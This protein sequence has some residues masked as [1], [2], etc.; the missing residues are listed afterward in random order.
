MGVFK[1]DWNDVPNKRYVLMGY[2]FSADTGA[3]TKEVATGNSAEVLLKALNN[4]GRRYDFY[5]LVDRKT[6]KYLSSLDFADTLDVLKQLDT[7]VELLE[8]VYSFSTNTLSN[9]RRDKINDLVREF[10]VGQLRGDRTDEFMNLI[11]GNISR[12]ETFLQTSQNHVSDNLLEAFR[13]ME[14]DIHSILKITQ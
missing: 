5:Q 7:Q 8:E 12:V 13:K 3:E 2:N 6:K 4:N 9:L 14:S 11:L 10:N 1:I